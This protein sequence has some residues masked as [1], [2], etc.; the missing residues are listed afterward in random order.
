MLFPRTVISGNK[1]TLTNC[2]I[3]GFFLGKGSRGGAGW[4]FPLKKD[5]SLQENILLGWQRRVFSQVAS[6][7]YSLRLALHAT[8]TLN[9]SRCVAPSLVSSQ[10][11]CNNWSIKTVEQIVRKVSLE[12]CVF[13]NSQPVVFLRIW[14][15]WRLITHL[16][17]VF[18]PFFPFFCVICCDWKISEKQEKQKQE[19]YKTVQ[20]VEENLCYKWEKK[21]EQ[22]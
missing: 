10:L 4:T 14:D 19:S 5:V 11:S 13:R 2:V 17:R 1:V 21:I 7:I 15:E 20:Q 6:H 9:V 3:A 8:P 22:V 16:L 18:P 12:S